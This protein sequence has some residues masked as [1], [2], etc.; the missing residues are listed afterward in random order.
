MII[1]VLSAASARLTAES[2]N[3]LI[4]PAPG[5]G[6]PTPAIRLTKRDN[7]NEEVGWHRGTALAA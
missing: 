1:V 2:L 6:P 3:A 5:S 7:Y 4:I